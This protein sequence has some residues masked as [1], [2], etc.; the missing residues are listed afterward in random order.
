MDEAR[1]DALRQL[2]AEYFYF[3]WK[4]KESTAR[5]FKPTGLK[6]DQMLLL[7]MIARGLARPKTI[8]EAMQWDPPLLSHYLSKLEAKGLI[9]RS[10]DPDDRRRTNVR[11]TDKGRALL[12]EAKRTWHMY[13]T[14]VLVDLSTE[15]IEQ[16][17]DL[18]RRILEKEAELAETRSGAG[19]GEAQ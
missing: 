18:L 12:E 11:I 8:A 5:L 7:G 3:L 14:Q 1:E 2:E 13:T 4:V 6:P 15:E 16:L 19:P 10:L 17:R 9:Q